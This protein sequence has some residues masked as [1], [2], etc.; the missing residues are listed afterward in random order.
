MHRFQDASGGH[1]SQ[2][3]R[4][5]LSFGI[6]ILLAIAVG[7]LLY[8]VP[9]HPRL[10][11]YAVALAAIGAVYVGSAL[12]EQRGR[13]IVLEVLIA[14]ACL[15]LALTGL[16]VSPL[17]LIAGYVLHGV[18]DFFHHPVHVGVQIPQRWYPPLCVGFDWAIA[19]M[20]I[21]QY[22]AG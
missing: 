13:S 14:I 12:V 6:G 3:Q 22:G 18:W 10:D 5:W 7:I 20:M 16:W 11:V 8:W 1:L 15:A 2:D 17:A 4:G 19:V 9:P 21:L